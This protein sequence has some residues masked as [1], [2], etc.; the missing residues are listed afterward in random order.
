[1]PEDEESTNAELLI[2]Y[3][4]NV[5]SSPVLYYLHTMDSNLKSNKH[6]L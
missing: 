3:I 5:I 6:F 1:M 2:L 4:H